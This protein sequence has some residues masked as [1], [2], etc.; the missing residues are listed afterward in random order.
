[1]IATQ[2]TICSYYCYIE[3]T[4]LVQKKNQACSIL[5]EM[6]KNTHDEMD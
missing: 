3:R 2:K 6:N 1:M 5:L 4:F